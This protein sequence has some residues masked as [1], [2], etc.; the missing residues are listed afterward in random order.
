MNAMP[1]TWLAMVV[2]SL[3]AT[4][5]AAEPP[6]IAI[7]SEIKGEPAAFVTVKATTKGS[8]WVRYA[9]VDSGLSVFPP[10]LLADPTV[11]VVV[12]AKAGRYRVL[13]YTGNDEGGAEAI[14][15]LVIGNAAPV[16]P[17]PVPTDPPV[18]D[19]VTPPD[20]TPGPLFFVIVRPNGPVPA[21]LEKLLS[22]PAWDAHRKAGRGVKAYTVAELGKRI[23]LPDGQRL[24]CV[25]TLR[26]SADGKS[27]KKAR[28]AID[29]PTTSDGIARL[30][31]G[32]K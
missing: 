5:A 22:D 18:V 19:P 11:T 24:P 13:A 8:A 3:V 9:P 20:A 12:A 1:K 30:H 16:T 25:V 26:V 21:D 17:T 15:T 29:L 31:E 7:P 6:T 32:V 10:N 28:D 23:E 4:F 2:M 27:S 14:V